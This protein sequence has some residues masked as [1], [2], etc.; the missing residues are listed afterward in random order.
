MF[1]FILCQKND[2]SEKRKGG[3]KTITAAINGEAN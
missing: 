1:P 3:Y 2:Q